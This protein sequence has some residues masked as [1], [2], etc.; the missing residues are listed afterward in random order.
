MQMLLVG[1][2]VAIRATHLV[3]QLI[4]KLRLLDKKMVTLHQ[5]NKMM[6]RRQQKRGMCAYHR[7][8]SPS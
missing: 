7:S 2:K 1:E 5:Q 3:L 6:A 8:L 4:R